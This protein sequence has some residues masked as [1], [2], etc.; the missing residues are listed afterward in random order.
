MPLVNFDSLKVL[1][2]FCCFATRLIK[3]ELQ[4]KCISENFAFMLHKNINSTLDAFPDTL[5]SNKKGLGIFEGS[6]RKFIN[7]I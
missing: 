3:H 7:L 4:E 6:F 5:H 2:H 1:I